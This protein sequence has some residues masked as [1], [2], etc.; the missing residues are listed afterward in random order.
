[1]PWAPKRP[2]THPGCPELTNGGRCARHRRE[3]QRAYNRARGSSARQG[4]GSRWRRAR[5]MYLAEHP[6]CEIC[7]RSGKLEPAA[8]VDHVVAHRSGGSFWDESNWQAL[9]KPC[10]DRKTATH[11][12]RWG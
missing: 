1:M 11:D 4:Y 5:A 6:L 9:C 3:E 12:G 7:R 2:C 8:V 10:H